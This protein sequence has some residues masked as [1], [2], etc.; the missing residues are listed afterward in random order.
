MPLTK[1]EH[2]LVMTDDIERSRDFYR[3]VIGLAVGFRADLGFAGYW[4]YLGD[5]PVIHIAEWE[6]YTAHSHQHGIPVTTRAHST[7]VFD[8]VAFNGHNAQEMI[9]KLVGL[10]VRFH[11]N[12]VPHVGLIQLFLFDPDGLKIELNY[13]G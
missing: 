11:R 13:R 5:I 4:L 2:Y 9:D 12:D 1:L 10:N 6:T 8:H 7:G 3:D